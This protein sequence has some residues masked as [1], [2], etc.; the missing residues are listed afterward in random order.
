LKMYSDIYERNSA[1]T[2]GIRFHR[3][4]KGFFIKA[5]PFLVKSKSCIKKILRR[6]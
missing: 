1:I 3:K 4:T 6:R 5:N 2:R